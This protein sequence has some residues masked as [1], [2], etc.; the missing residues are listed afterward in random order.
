MASEVGHTA[1]P[2]TFDGGDHAPVLHLYAQDGKHLFHGERSLAEQE[3]NAAF[4]V[5][6]CNAHD[7]L[8]A[9]VGELIRIREWAHDETG[10]AC[11]AYDGLADRARDAL[12]KATP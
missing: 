3:A 9:I 12:A 8:V 4:I 7:E 6:A 2:W 11:A 1:T 5:R 10:A